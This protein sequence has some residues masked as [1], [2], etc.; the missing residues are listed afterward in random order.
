MKNIARR[1]PPGFTPRTILEKFPSLRMADGRH[2]VGPHC[3]QPDKD[4][5]LLPQRFHLKDTRNVVGRG[6]LRRRPMG[7][8]VR[9]INGLDVSNGR[10]ADV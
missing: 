7:V 8:R 1:H 6:C 10:M 3:M 2:L 4:I 5:K 9:K